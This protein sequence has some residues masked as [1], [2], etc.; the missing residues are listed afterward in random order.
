MG[1]V[2]AY[3]LSSGWDEFRTDHLQ[4]LLFIEQFRLDIAPPISSFLPPPQWKKRGKNVHS[5]IHISH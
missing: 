2:F 4:L 5:H 3:D 1:K